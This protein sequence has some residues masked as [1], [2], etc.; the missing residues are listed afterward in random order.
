[1]KISELIKELEKSLAEYGDVEV[2]V[3][4]TNFDWD[5]SEILEVWSV[6]IQETFRDKERRYLII[7]KNSFLFEAEGMTPYD[8]HD[9]YKNFLKTTYF[10]KKDT[11]EFMKRFVSCDNEYDQYAVIEDMKNFYQG[12]N[13][14]DNIERLLWGADTLFNINNGVTI[15]TFMKFVER[16]EKEEE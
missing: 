8:M 10:G 16:L 7:G 3:T 1:M 15:N 9:I 11:L 5:Y 13:F 12:N 2:V 4:D 6:G 14:D